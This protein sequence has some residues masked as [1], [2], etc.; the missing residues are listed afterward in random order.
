MKYT[1][2]QLDSR[3]QD[4]KK[5]LKLP[6]EAENID[7]TLIIQAFTN[8]SGVHMIPK[9][10][11]DSIY[12]PEYGI[13][14][15]WYEFVGDTILETIIRTMISELNIVDTFKFGH[16]LK[17]TIVKNV[18]LECMMQKKDLCKYIIKSNNAINNKICADV[19][20]AIIGILFY[21]LYYV[22]ALGF[23][24][25]D[26]IRRWIVNNWTLQEIILN[27]IEYGCITCECKKPEPSQPSISNPLIQKT[28][29]KSI[30]KSPKTHPTKKT[31]FTTPK[32]I[33]PNYNKNDEI[34]IQKVKASLNNLL[35]QNLSDEDRKLILQRENDIDNYGTIK[36]PSINVDI[37]E[38]NEKYGIVI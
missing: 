1:T 3:V 30:S 19:F 23:G 12:A 26:I 16:E 36:I 2:S 28:D 15:E 25:I 22:K 32:P 9:L 10:W 33:K 8:S 17:V 21:H 37:A 38:L 7:K 27:Y 18:S 34:K 4:I 5:I 14:Y 29:N 31:S 11:I 35:K 20:E 6:K 24:S 13:D